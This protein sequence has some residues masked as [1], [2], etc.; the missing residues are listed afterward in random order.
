MRIAFLG[1]PDF[2]VPALDALRATGH[3]VACVYTQPPRPA[4][5]GQSE[6]RSPVHEHADAAGI[7]VRTPATLREEEA[8]A[9]FAALNLDVAVVVAYGLILPQPV[10]DAPRLGCINIHASLLPRWRGAAPIQRAI[11]AGD[12]ETGVTIM[13]MDAGLDTGP[14][15]LREAIPITSQT[16]AGMLHDALAALGGR[17]IVEALAGLEAGTLNAVAQPD[18]GETYAAKIARGEERIDWA[19]PATVLDRHV[20]AFAPWP[21]AWF[22]HDGERIKVL[23]VDVVAGHGKPGVVLDDAL[24]VA[25]GE[26]GLRL[27]TVQRAGK[28]A[29]AAA[30]YLRGRP[31]AAGAVFT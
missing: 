22:E 5:R 12:A 1:T 30:D 6:R 17:L 31:V 4:G 20:R 18:T 25:C 11:Q 23:A 19:Q 14:E 27:V 15:L 26:G 28:A 8:Q 10:L 3:E 21:G 2:S 9:E 29:M 7:P 16:N 24:T 13:Q